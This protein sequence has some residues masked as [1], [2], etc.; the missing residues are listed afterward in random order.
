M[1]VLDKALYIPRTVL[2]CFLTVANPLA[3]QSSRLSIAVDRAKAQVGEEVQ[4]ILEVFVQII[5]APFA[6][7]VSR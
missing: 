4:F 7:N 3:A 1:S 5:P 2:V 6:M